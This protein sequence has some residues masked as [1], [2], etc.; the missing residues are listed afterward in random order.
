MQAV[1][2]SRGVVES[3]TGL[4]E[5]KKGFYGLNDIKLP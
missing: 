3:Y 5:G 2:G 1:A 4:N